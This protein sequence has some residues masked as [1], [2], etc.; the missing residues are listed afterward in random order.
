MDQQTIDAAIYNLM[1]MDHNGELALPE[2]W[3]NNKGETIVA[4]TPDDGSV[5]HCWMNMLGL[6]DP[7]AL[8]AGTHGYLFNPQIPRGPRR[9]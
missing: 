5:L 6:D 4:W 3:L 1:V 9:A 7:D 8:A 2:P